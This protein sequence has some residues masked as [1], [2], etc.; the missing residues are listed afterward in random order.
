MNNLTVDDI[1][2]IRKEHAVLTQNMSFDE[3]KADLHKEIEP[4]LD[5][6][7]SMKRKQKMSATYFPEIGSLVVAEPQ[8]TYRTENVKSV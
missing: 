3:Y 8:T 6:L 1:H 4:L 7:K 5:L 2:R